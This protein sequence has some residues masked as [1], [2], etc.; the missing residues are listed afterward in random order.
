MN[1]SCRQRRSARAILLDD[2]GRVPLI[3]FAVPRNGASFSFWAT[4]GGGVENGETDLA[5]ARREIYEELHLG[6]A[7][8]GPVHIGTAEF[9][10]E[11]VPIKSIDVFFVGRYDGDV[12]GFGRLT[13]VERGIPAGNSVVVRR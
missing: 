12:P 8:A 10:H 6:V 11:G 5:V 2:S 1:S 7:L 9:E 3:R 13:E 4:P